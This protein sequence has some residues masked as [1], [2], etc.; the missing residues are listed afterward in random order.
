VEFPGFLVYVNIG[1]SANTKAL[2]NVFPTKM[3]FCTVLAPGSEKNI[4]I[5]AV[6][7]NIPFT[8]AIRLMEEILHQLI[9]LKK[10]MFNRVLCIPGG[11]AFLPP[12]VHPK[13]FCHGFFTINVP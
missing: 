7:S 10:H 8:P 4:G 9:C 1:T 12:T 11:A 6:A 2:G 13:S 3:L 5:Y